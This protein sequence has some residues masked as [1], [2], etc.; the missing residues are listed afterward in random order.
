MSEPEGPKAHAE[1]FSL[2]DFLPLPDANLGETVAAFAELYGR[3]AE[4][5]E[6]LY[7]RELVSAPGPTVRLR[8]GDSEREF[9]MLGSNNYLGLATHPKVLA[10]AHAAIDRWGYG[11]GGPPLLNGTS[12][13]HRELEAALAQLKGTED[14]LLFSSGFLTNLGWLTAL[15]RPQDVVLYDEWSHASLHDA[16][17]LARCKARHFAHNDVAE[18]EALLQANRKQHPNANL[19]VAVEGVYSMDGDL[20]PLPAIAEACQRHGAWLVVDDAHGT[21][22]LGTHGAGATSHWKLPPEAVALHMG[23]FSK[24]FATTGGFLA[25][26]K[27]LIAYLR[28]YARSHMFSAALPP[29]VVAGVLAG[30]EVMAE[31]PQRQRQLHANRLHLV[32]SLRR[33]GLDVHSDSAIVPVVVGSA[34]GARRLAAELHQRGVFANAVEPPAVPAESQRLRLSLMAT[35]TPAQ[36]DTVVAAI[37][38]AGRVLGLLPPLMHA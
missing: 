22:V 11:M 15:A 27:E 28:F 10:A 38:S 24:S 2:R 29:P 1:N 16:L 36:L 31:E 12:A 21:G 7:M 26:K 8:E 30:I 4:A 5:G 32:G 19:L 9:I 20:A 13:L 14:A 18:L 3:A 35:H 33:L 37:G 6:L 17:K 25:G 34:V 23:T